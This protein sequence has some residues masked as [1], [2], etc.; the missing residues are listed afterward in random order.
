MRGAV[1][2]YLILTLS[3]SL[4][5]MFDC[6]FVGIPFLTSKQEEKLALGR[7]RVTDATGYRRDA[8]LHLCVT[9]ETIRPRSLSAR[10]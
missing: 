2:K 8:H 3:T 4:I 6:N 10:G 1:S 5:Q 9:A 7:V